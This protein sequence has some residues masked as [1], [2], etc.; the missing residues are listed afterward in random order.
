M[1]PFSGPSIHG[2]YI[3]TMKWIGWMSGTG[4]PGRERQKR[5]VWQAG[6]PGEGGPT[7]RS[8]LKM[9]GREQVVVQVLADAGQVRDDVDAERAQV[10]R[11]PDPREQEELRRPDRP[12][13]HDDLLGLRA[14]DAAVLRPLDADA[15]RAVEQQA[16]R[17]RAGD[18][19]EVRVGLDRTDVRRR[20]A[21]PDAVLDAVLHERH[22][23][24]RR[25]VVVGVQR[26][27]ALLR[28]LGDRH[29]DRVRLE[30]R[31][32][33][34]GARPAGLSPLDA[35]VDRAYVLPRPAVGAE[36][37]P[38]VEVLGRAAHPDHRVEA[39]RAAEDPAARPGEPAAG[40]VHLRHGLVGPVDLGEPEL[41]DPAGIVDRGVLV[42]PAG[43]EQEDAGAPLSTSRRATTAPAEPEPTTTT[44]ALRSLTRRRWRSAWA[45]TT[46]EPP[47]T[48]AETFSRAGTT[49]APPTAPEDRRQPGPTVALPQIGR[50]KCWTL[51]PVDGRAGGDLPS[52]PPAPPTFRRRSNR[53][54]RTIGPAGRGSRRQPH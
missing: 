34:H 29:V 13:A 7:S 9:T 16:P 43:L 28:R 41:V 20:G 11:R 45:E 37:R 24:L 27:A 19:L 6:R 33:A 25:A 35:L 48:P 32:Q 22:A 47:D 1:K 2:S 14:L 5:C 36:I 39:A 46:V 26:D 53:T 44:S 23:V 42:A 49:C 12:A 54:I 50:A 15:A 51:I 4:S 31:E 3:G 17:D 40:R 8:A 21:V 18:Q 52:Q 30:R 38:R 10:I